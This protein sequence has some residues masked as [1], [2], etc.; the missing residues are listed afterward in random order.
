M[1]EGDS[2]RS[3][4]RERAEAFFGKVYTHTL[5][6]KQTEMKRELKG[7]LQSA[8]AADAA[9]DSFYLYCELFSLYT[10]TKGK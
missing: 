3:G 8:E 2:R 5:Q 6:G 10:P 7:Y 9:R 1:S 4:N